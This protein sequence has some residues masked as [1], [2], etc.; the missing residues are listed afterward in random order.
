MRFHGVVAIIW[1]GNRLDALSSV[2]PSHQSRGVFPFRAGLSF[3]A[4]VIPRS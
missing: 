2:Q 4:S 3:R 1:E